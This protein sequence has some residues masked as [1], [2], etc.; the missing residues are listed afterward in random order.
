MLQCPDRCCVSFPEVKDIGQ[1]LL[2]SLIS[3]T[4]E[5][6]RQSEKYYWDISSGI[7]NTY[8]PMPYITLTLN[9]CR[10]TSYLL[11][12]IQTAGI[13]PDYTLHSYVTGSLRSIHIQPLLN[14]API[15][16]YVYAPSGTNHPGAIYP[17]VCTSILLPAVT[18]DGIWS[19]PARLYREHT[20][21]LPRG[22]SRLLSY[23][24][25]ILVQTPP[26]LRQPS[27]LKRF[28]TKPSFFAYHGRE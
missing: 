19:A 10:K 17:Y 8:S 14:P 3:R 27:A 1:R 28:H 13:L 16:M 11:P 12:P 2:K 7:S 18:K 5:W 25:T 4:G 23:C 15:S 20:V 9:R 6:G 24:S 22:C 26:Q 21:S